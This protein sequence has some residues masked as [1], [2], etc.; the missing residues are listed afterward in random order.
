MGSI[1]AVPSVWRITNAALIFPCIGSGTLV[2]GY[3]FCDNSL[4]FWPK[5]ARDRIYQT[6]SALVH[7]VYR[8]ADAGRLHFVVQQFNG[9]MAGC[10]VV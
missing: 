6:L 9:E 8:I 7:A 3:W 2:G 10:L 5:P 4:V 1:G